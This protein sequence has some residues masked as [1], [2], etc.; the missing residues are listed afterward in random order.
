MTVVESDQIAAAAS[1]V[2][3]TRLTDDVRAVSRARWTSAICPSLALALIVALFLTNVYRAATQS[4]THDE[5]VTYESF[6]AEKQYRIFTRFDANH[7]LLNTY[8]CL[9]T[10]SLCGVSEFSMRI[11]SLLGGALYLG[12]MYRLCRTLYG[13]GPVFLLAVCVL[14]LN[15]F[16]LDFLS[17]ARGYSL[18]L[19]FCAWTLFELVRHGT[20]T[21]P[22][23]APLV[24][25][26]GLPAGPAPAT[27][28]NGRDAE[29]RGRGDT[30]RD[31][32]VSPPLRVSVSAGPGTATAA[33]SRSAH[34]T[35]SHGTAFPQAAAYDSKPEDHDAER[36]A[37]LTRHAPPASRSHLRKLSL[38]MALTVLSNL[39]FLPVMAALA[40]VY[41]TL[42]LT[43][44]RLGRAP[45]PFGN[46]VLDILH[47]LV[48]P[49]LILFVLLGTALFRARPGD[50]YVGD[51][52]AL[53]SMLGII[54]ASLGHHPTEWP[55]DNDGPTLVGC[56]AVFSVWGNLCLF[57]TMVSFCGWIVYRWRRSQ[58]SLS[59]LDQ[60]DR[61]LLLAGAS[62]VMTLA[63]IYVLHG[64]L[65]VKYPFERTGLYLVPIYSLCVLSTLNKL[66]SFP[67][68][69]RAAGYVVFAVATVVVGQ[70]AAQWPT[71]HYRTWQ[72]DAST[73]QMF[74]AILAR[75]EAEGGAYGGTVRVAASEILAPSLNFYRRTRQAFWMEE[76]RTAGSVR[77][78]D[79][80]VIA[81]KAHPPRGAFTALSK[82]AETGTI[83]AIPQRTVHVGN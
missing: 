41:A 9:L 19:G 71:G 40:V 11:P 61:F 15:P 29:T 25:L 28:A 82:D 27:H 14:C 63:A 20:D 45:R 18:A 47:G 31:F 83:L 46:D 72:Y 81:P 67:G 4:I 1:R 78:C 80:Y 44:R 73:R 69:R 54:W 77:D 76:I 58:T 48:K 75:Y 6:L 51:N 59:L 16:L 36:R 21:F 49:G 50:F 5:A 7:H 12:M 53:M 22:P 33:T 26:P 68:P 70:F 3:G 66:L 32:S 62:F 60:S 13:N 34:P 52:S 23:P 8:L 35:A 79:F 17:L 74:N 55:F 65:H 38:L 43:N 37:T 57:L 2:P 42:L 24:T 56:V 10:T 30:G 39:T 64:L